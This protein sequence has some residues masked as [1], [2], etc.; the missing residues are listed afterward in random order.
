LLG[1]D[2]VASSKFQEYRVVPKGAS[3]PT[4]TFGG[5]RNGM[6]FTLLSQNIAQTDQRYTG[7]AT[8]PWG[9]VSFDYNQ[10]PHAIGND[11]RSIMTPLG[12]GVWGMSATTR[13]ALGNSVAAR[14]PT[15]TR[16]YDF[17]SALYAPTIASAGFVDLASQRQ[18]GNVE[19]RLG[20]N[21]PFDLAVSYLR[22]VKTGTRGAGGG[23]IRSFADNIVEVPEPLNEVIQDLGFRLAVNR[24]WGN[25]HAGFNRNWY[26]DRQET[27]IIDNP[28]VAFDQ[29]YR[30]AAGSIPASGGTSRALFINPPDNSAN[31]GSFGGLLKLARQTRLAADA[32]IGRWKQNAQLYP[33]T[34]FSLAVTGTGAPAS[35]RASLQFQS[36]N[37]KIDT[38]SLKLLF[39][40]RPVEG[41]G[42][43]AR[44][45][46]YDLDNKTPV[47]P[48][49]GSFSAS[50]DRLWSNTNLTTQPLGYITASPYGYTSDRSDLSASY[51]IKA[52]T[53]EAAYRY[54]KVH[55][56]YR[57]AEE[58]K[59]TGVTLSAVY[60]TSDWLRVRGFVDDASRTAAGPGVTAATRLP[61]DEAVRDS[62]RAGI[63]VEV[64]PNS[65]VGFVIAYLRRSA[66]Y[67]N[68][69]AVA[70]VAG[71]AN[72]LIEAKYDSF[73]GE[74]D[75]T[76]NERLEVNF[77]YTYEK[78]LS[79]TNGFSG[80]TTLRGLLRFEGSD[81]TDT[82]GANARFQ[83]VPEKWGATLA[84][85]SQKLDGLMDITG[86]PNGS[87]A[88]ARAAYGGIQDITDYSDTELRTASAQLDYTVSTSWGLSVGY[89]YEKY[90]FADAFSAGTDIFPLSGAF[91]VKANDGAY[92]ANGAFARLNYRF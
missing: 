78:N 85:R 54:G 19:V 64:N 67:R 28:L 63:D 26:N 80:G 69:D 39:S 87:F 77:Y 50:P 42:L 88:L 55:R 59:E 74:I 82:F 10:I 86:D 9:R 27:L 44:Y 1:R 5:H 43:R 35:D 13:Q 2:N 32:S 20:E 15:S 56:T 17:F 51:D 41:L 12:P 79:T 60:H 18:R 49:I 31:T 83:L 92:T 66:D 33:Y 71:T 40:S 73:T 38:T 23:T 81:K 7:W 57:E 37:G 6:D 72:G 24:R 68:P 30:P 70:G 16:T 11:G 52:V 36:L 91:Y 53:F 8:A 29:P 62:T 46:R 84:V 45:R 22:E 89:F 3:V 4:F 25:V 76:P 65:R 47:I 90:N 34:I 14:L 21:L 75:L 48:R 58:G 61:A